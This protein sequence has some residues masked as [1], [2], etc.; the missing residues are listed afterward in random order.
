MKAKSTA[1]TLLLLIIL[2]SVAGFSQTQFPDF[3]KGTWKMEDKE[4]YEHWDLLNE[5]TLKGVSYQLKNGKPEISE[6]LDISGDQT[7]TIYTATV[8]KQN[9]GKG[10]RFKLDQTAD[11]Y[12][13]V[14]PAHDFPKKI[15]YKQLSAT[16]LLVNISDGQS[17]GLSFKMIKLAPE[18]QNDQANNQNPEYDPVLAQ[19][20][21]ADDYGMKPYYLVV[22][23]TGSNTTTDKTFVN[24]CFRGHLQNINR[25]VELGKLIVAG[26]LEKNDKTYRGI[27]ILNVST[28]EEAENLL[29]TDPAIQEG[30]LGF[31]LFRWFG[32]AALPAYLDFS[33]KVWKVKP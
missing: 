9:R 25:L 20:Y 32:S 3:L 10:I 11:S 18:I 28:T 31:E 12:T 16:E 27:F 1:V 24:A 26:P 29:L 2:S 14:N 21:G 17:E 15:V 30:L 33:K 19:K 4:I 6:Y 5:H 7:E 23:K 13:F 8:I 22:L